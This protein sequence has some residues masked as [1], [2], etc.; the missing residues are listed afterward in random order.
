MLKRVKDL[1]A[2]NYSK[3]VY[4]YKLIK[5]KKIKGYRDEDGYLCYDDAEIETYNKTAKRGRPIKVI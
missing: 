4:V 3:G 2:T 5:D 1:R